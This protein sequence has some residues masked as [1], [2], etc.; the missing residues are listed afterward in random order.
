MHYVGIVSAYTIQGHS[1]RG[2]I[3]VGAKTKVRCRTQVKP[4]LLTHGLLRL[5][6]LIM[7]S[8]VVDSCHPSRKD[9]QKVWA[10][11][12]SAAQ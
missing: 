11:R 2:T 3:T 10:T 4:S 5:E 6:G 8:Y 12:A 1:S 9:C 7:I